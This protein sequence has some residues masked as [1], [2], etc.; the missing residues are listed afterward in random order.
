MTREDFGEWVKLHRP[1]AII[2]YEGI[3]NWLEELGYRIPS[4]IGFAT[5]MGKPEEGVRDFSGIDENPRQTG[6]AVVDLLV[7]MMQRG[8][9]GV[10][11]VPNCLLVYP[12]WREGDTLRYLNRSDSA[13]S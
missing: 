13:S 7:G 6:A 11:E 8:E 2:S 5:F 10:P 4:D 3:A 12:S 1:D 9:R